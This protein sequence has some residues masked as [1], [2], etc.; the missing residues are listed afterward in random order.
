M[1]GIRKNIENW[2]AKSSKSDTI[3]R[4]V[5]L[6]ILYFSPVVRIHGALCNVSVGT[7]IFP[8]SSLFTQ[9]SSFISLLWGFYLSS[10]YL[11]VTH[12]DYAKYNQ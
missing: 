8:S 11:Y 12:T 3:S 6:I 10:S 5:A 1:Y 2:V 9:Y 7:A 4:N